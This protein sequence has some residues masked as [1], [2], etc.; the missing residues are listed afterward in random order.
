MNEFDIVGPIK[1]GAEEGGFDDGRSPERR[2]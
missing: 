1:N 2:T